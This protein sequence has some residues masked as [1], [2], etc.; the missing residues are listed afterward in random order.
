MLSSLQEASGGRNWMMVVGGVACLE[1][2]IL[3]CRPAMGLSTRVPHW[4]SGM[5]KGLEGA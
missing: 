3:I 1:G 4:A 2:P 5:I